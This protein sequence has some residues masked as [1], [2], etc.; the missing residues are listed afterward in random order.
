MT[1]K[2]QMKPTSWQGEGEPQAHES[3]RQCAPVSH[4]SAPCHAANG[5]HAT[6]AAKLNQESQSSFRVYE[7]VRV[8]GI[9]GPGRRRDGPRARPAGRRGARSRNGLGH[10]Q[11]ELRH[12]HCDGRARPSRSL[13]PVRAT[14]SPALPVH[15]P[16]AAP[17]PPP[18]RRPG[19]RTLRSSGQWA[20][21]AAAASVWLASRRTSSTLPG[22]PAQAAGAA[23]LHGRGG[24]G[25]GGSGSSLRETR[26][27]HAP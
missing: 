4:D 21:A 22:K 20:A 5:N 14:P 19:C 11:A 25:E 1:T 27:F 17:Q 18:G 3:A 6:A 23:T 16:E 13:E 8:T 9:R 7:R 26:I 24:R 10:T 12:S 2:G 15:Q